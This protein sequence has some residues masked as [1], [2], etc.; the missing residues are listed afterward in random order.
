MNTESLYFFSLNKIIINIE[1]KCKYINPTNI[2]NSKIILV[3][4]L[5]AIQAECLEMYY[6][7]YLVI[8]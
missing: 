7:M 6:C 8:F 5:D 3:L 1:S 2:H 4:I